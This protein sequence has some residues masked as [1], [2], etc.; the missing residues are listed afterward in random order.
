MP[1]AT[2]PVGVAARPDASS[3]LVWWA[4]VP[5]SPSNFAP[6]PLYSEHPSRR[7]GR[8]VLGA[9]RWH[10][11]KQVSGRDTFQRCLTSSRHHPS[12]GSMRPPHPCPWTPCGMSVR[13]IFSDPAELHPD[14]GILGGQEGRFLEQ[15]V[16]P[17]K[18][19]GAHPLVAWGTHPAHTVMRLGGWGMH[20]LMQV[21]Q[22]PG[23]Q[24]GYWWPS[25]CGWLQEG[26]C[27]KKGPGSP[28]S[29]GIS[30]SVRHTVLKAR[31]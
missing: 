7:T 12:C 16:P 17:Q 25:L 9:E 22:Q 8:D 3:Y 29:P 23:A 1:I 21:P 6:K 28:E 30:L 24:S 19:R 11:R 5:S 27:Y 2:S 18:A 10:R 13:T 26:L 31:G 20:F 4:G 14:D 15:G